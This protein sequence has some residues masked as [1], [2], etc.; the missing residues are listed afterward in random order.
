MP[1][2]ARYELMNEPRRRQAEREAKAQFERELA[3]YEA[4]VA[5][6]AAAE[7]AAAE[8][9]REEK[10]R[11]REAE[12][13]RWRVDEAAAAEEVARLKKDFIARNKPKSR[14]RGTAPGLRDLLTTVHGWAQ[15]L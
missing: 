10:A 3:A 13:A 4:A 1:A 7:A 11:A 5:A 14:T 9:A 2:A 12:A 6:A 15:S 8:A